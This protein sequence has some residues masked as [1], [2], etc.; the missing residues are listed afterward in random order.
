MPSCDDDVDACIIPAGRAGTPLRGRE[1][2]A[3]ATGSATASGKDDG[4]GGVTDWGQ[5]VT[6]CES[7]AGAVQAA[8]DEVVS[9]RTTGAA[10]AEASGRAAGT[11]RAGATDLAGEV[12]EL[13]DKTL[14]CMIGTRVGLGG[15]DAITVLGPVL[16]ESAEKSRVG[17][18]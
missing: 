4:T 14:A 2:A 1:G 12:L 13:T 15:S 10:D 8:A 18:T 16:A 7:A 11:V 5:R 17:V 3:R 6:D 9:G